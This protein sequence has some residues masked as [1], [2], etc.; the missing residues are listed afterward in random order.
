MNG[1]HR[2]LHSVSFYHI[3]IKEFIVSKFYLFNEG[4]IIPENDFNLEAG[5]IKMGKLQTLG[6][7]INISVFTRGRTT[8]R[9]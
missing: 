7:I 4:K 6:N 5:T 8:Q 3:N 1:Y 9:S 2:R